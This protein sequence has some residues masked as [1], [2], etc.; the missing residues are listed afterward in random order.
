MSGPT[1]LPKRR[2]IPKN[3]RVCREKIALGTIGGMGS[4]APYKE[5]M[6]SNKRKAAFV[7]G[8][9]KTSSMLSQAG[10][11]TSDRYLLIARWLLVWVGPQ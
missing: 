1:I 10:W 7:C 4:P 6:I 9:Y 5:G 2:I 11:R 3:N 8:K